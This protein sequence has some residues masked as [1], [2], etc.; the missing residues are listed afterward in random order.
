MRQ[1][2]ILGKVVTLVLDDEWA[3]FNYKKTPL[4]VGNLLLLLFA[5]RHDI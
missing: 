5:T 2:D 1:K 4:L 3:N